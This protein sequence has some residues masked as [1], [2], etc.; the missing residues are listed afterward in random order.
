[1]RSRCA[2]NSFSFHHALRYDPLQE[3][4][5][6]VLFHRILR[7]F[8]LRLLIAVR[9]PRAHVTVII[10]FILVIL[11]VVIGVDFYDCCR[12][13]CCWGWLSCGSR[14]HHDQ[15]IRSRHAIDQRA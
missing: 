4:L 14:Q 8:R 9:M 11:V 2:H 13:W 1:L 15:L 10:L 7:F 5:L 12:S 3:L 6:T